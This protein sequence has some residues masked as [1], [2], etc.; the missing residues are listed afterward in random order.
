MKLF[1]KTLAAGAVLAFAVMG[2]TFAEGEFT[3]ENELS[4]DTYHFGNGYGDNNRFP[5]FEERMQAEYTSEKVDVNANF[6]LEISGHNEDTADGKKVIFS[7]DGINFYPNAH[8]SFVKFR[9]VDVLQLSIAYFWGAEKAAGSYL[10]VME[11]YWSYTSFGRYTG[12]FGLLFKPMDGLSIGAGID[13]GYLFQDRWDYND[14]YLDLIFGAEYEVEDIGSFAVTFNDV[15]NHFAVGAFA[16]ISAVQTMDIYA[17]LAYQKDRNLRCYSIG[18]KLFANAGLELKNVEKFSLAAELVTNFFTEADNT[19]DL[20]TGF[21]AG[22]DV[23]ENFNIGA[24][25]RMWFDLTDTRNDEYVDYRSKPDFYICPEL[26]YKLGNN[27]FKAGV[28]MEF[29][30]DYFWGSIPLSWTYSF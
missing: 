15:V 14:K 20:Y 10:P 25:T 18:G 26:T 16:K 12:N 3:F 29:A 9:P 8:D 1:H 4:T 6:S 19:Y 5:N 22:Y 24:K 23:N 13:T 30:G 28:G 2:T 17:G 11:E 21:R 7:L 27:T